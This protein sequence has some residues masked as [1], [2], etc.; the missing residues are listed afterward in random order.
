MARSS[1][2]SLLAETAHYSFL[3]VPFLLKWGSRLVGKR[4][5]VWGTMSLDPGPNPESRVHGVIREC[6]VATGA[7]T[8]AAHVAAVFTTMNETRADWFYDAKKPSGYWEGTVAQSGGH[9]IL[10]DLKP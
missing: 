6:S 8:G 7:P 9:F 2:D 10:T 5:S 3:D 4:I 1:S